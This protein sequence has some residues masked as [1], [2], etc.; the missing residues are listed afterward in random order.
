M[1]LFLLIIFSFLASGVQAIENYSYVTKWGTFGEGEGEF[2]TPVYATLDTAGNVLVT[3]SRNN[4]VQIFDSTGRFI[5]TWKTRDPETGKL[6]TPKGIACDAFGNVYLTDSSN[7]RVWKFSRT[8]I[9]ITN[10]GG[11]GEKPGQF[12]YPHDVAVDSSSGVV[13][14]TDENNHRVQKF[15]GG[16]TYITSW[17]SH[18]SGEGQFSAPTGITVDISGNIYVADNQN[19]RIQKFTDN[20]T[21]ITSWGTQGSEEG[22]LYWPWGIAVDDTGGV[23][24]ADLQNDRIQKFSSNGR[25]ITAWGRYGTADGE[26]LRPRSVAVYGEGSKVYVVDSDNSRI[27]MF[28]TIPVILHLNYSPKI[29]VTGPETKTIF[30]A[31]IAEVPGYEICG[32]EWDFLNG[33]EASSRPEER[34]GGKT[35]LNYSQGKTWQYGEYGNKQL[36]VKLFGKQNGENDPYLLDQKDIDFK[37][38]FP[39]GG[40]SDWKTNPYASPLNWR[41]D[42]SILTNE[43][44]W[45]HYWKREG[46]IEKINL[47][48]YDPG[49]GSAGYYNSSTGIIALGPAAPTLWNTITLNTALEPD[50][51]T[52]GGTVGI[53]GATATVFHELHHE[54]IRL[55]RESGIFSGLHDSDYNNSSLRYNYRADGRSYYQTSNDNL[56]D[57]FENGTLTTEWEPRGSQTDINHTDTYNFRTH[58]DQNYITY[59]DEEYLCYREENRALGRVEGFVPRYDYTKDWS[60]GGRMAKEQADSTVPSTYSSERVTIPSLD[61]TIL[62]SE[63]TDDSGFLHFVDNGLDTNGN[64]LYNLLIVDVTLGVDYPGTYTLY[65]NLTDEEGTF[66]ASSSQRIPLATNGIFEVTLQF[67]GTE[68]H[69]SERNGPYILNVILSE[70][71]GR[72]AFILDNRAYAH[73]TES[74]TPSQFEGAQISLTDTY[75]DFAIDSDGDGTLDFLRIDT[76]LSVTH[77]GRYKVSAALYGYSGHITTAFYEGEFYMGE[78]IAPLLFSGRVIGLQGIDGPYEL[79]D[80]VIMSQDNIQIDYNRSPYRTHD[81]SKG[82]FLPSPPNATFITAPHKGNAPLTVNFTDMSTKNPDAFRWEYNTGI[83][84]RTFSQLKNPQ[85]TFFEPGN[86]SIRLTAKNDGGINTDTQ[87]DRVIVNIQGD[88]NGNGH[89]DIGDVSKVAWMALEQIKPDLAADFNKD[90]RV[91]GADAAIIAYYYVGKISEL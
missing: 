32:L 85:Y 24:V 23:Y 18:G 61:Q 49:T 33:T 36:Q 20:G 10:W 58:F 57:A 11:Y 41:K 83:G 68:I 82:D 73:L 1:I 13:Y 38:F 50:G 21:Y 9:F 12:I 81:Y 53:T 47:T 86:Y 69:Q 51:E 16:G 88:F 62:L 87:I 78:N 37:V 39:M 59:G 65:G 55:T 28:T 70:S 30:S 4:R 71:G 25:F 48:T 22:Q 8:G 3:E 27:Q 31:V 89:V 44:N 45:Y 29:P 34:L 72:E 67:N 66:I 79:R 14:V 74:Y 42:P 43:P 40:P 75:A 35:N 5:T 46:S 15:T 52:I 56:P 63:E 26:F 91:N 60:D 17:G 77:A 2:R 7:H 76:G 90:G 80:V 64:G 19:H 84:W 6:F 54:T